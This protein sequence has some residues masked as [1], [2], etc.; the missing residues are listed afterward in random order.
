MYSEFFQLDHNFGMLGWGARGTCGL[1]AAPEA[2]HEPLVF[3]ERLAA[4]PRRLLWSTLRPE[5][6]K[7]ELRKAAA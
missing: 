2:I 1:R 6:L 3:C 4:G 5:E 7:A